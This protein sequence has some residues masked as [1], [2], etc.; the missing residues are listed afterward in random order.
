MS[1]QC[2]TDLALLSIEKQLSQNLPLDEVIDR[3]AAADNNR[4]EIAAE[5]A[6]NDSENARKKRNG[7]CTSVHAAATSNEKTAK[8]SETTSSEINKKS[9][10]KSLKL[11]EDNKVIL[12]DVSVLKQDIKKLKERVDKLESQLPMT[13]TPTKIPPSTSKAISIKE[14]PNENKENSDGN[15]EE[16]DRNE[17]GN[18]VGNKER[19]YDGNNRRSDDDHGQFD[20][21]LAW[22]HCSLQWHQLDRRKYNLLMNI[23]PLHLLM[24]AQGLFLY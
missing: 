2:L 8:S 22:P 15:K 6:E 4:T 12:R 13:S 14:K 3:F 1:A 17:V 20:V 9:D 7:T 11:E 24:G 16:P 18:E 23:R 21:I 10:K 5:I 19:P